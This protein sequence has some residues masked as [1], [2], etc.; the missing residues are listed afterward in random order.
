M[1]PPNPVMKAKMS[2]MGTTRPTNGAALHEGEPRNK[3][4]AAI[5]ACLDYL[6]REAASSRLDE[7]ARFL[8]V[9]AELALEESRKPARRRKKRG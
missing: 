5:A 2:H 6:G 8:D 4:A 7:L 1:S 3:V 9:A